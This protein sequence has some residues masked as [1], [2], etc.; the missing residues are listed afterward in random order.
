MSARTDYP[1]K[2]ITIESQGYQLTGQIAV[3]PEGEA[4]LAVV[5]HP[6][7]GVPA[8]FYRHFAAWVA[9]EHQA[10]VLTYDYRQFGASLGSMPMREADATMTDWGVADQSAALGAI[11]AAYPDLPVWVIGHSLGGMFLAWHDDAHRVTRQISIASGPAHLST[12]PV[13]FKPMAF[14]FWMLGGPAFTKMMGYMPGRLAGLGPDLPAGVYW[15]WRRWCTSRQ[16]YEVDWGGPIPQPDLSRAKADLTIIGITDDP[17]IPVRQT[18]KLARF[19]PSVASVT[20]RQ[21]SPVDAGVKRIGHLNV[22]SRTCQQAWPKLV[23]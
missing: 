22:F 7:T 19:Y 1:A 10:A 9:R 20:R 12:H 3:P 13:S 15:Q 16:F 5:I 11:C 23:A 21:V 8:R 18:E 4:E 2:A 17:M 6:A 14:Y